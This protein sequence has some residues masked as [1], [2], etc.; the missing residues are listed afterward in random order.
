RQLGV[1]GE[2]E[3]GRLRVQHVIHPILVERHVPGD[4]DRP[5]AGGR[6]LDAHTRGRLYRGQHGVVVVGAG[7]GGRLVV[8][9]VPVAGDEVVHQVDQLVGQVVAKADHV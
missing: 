9:E 4:G 7:P 3:W 6:R 5:I 1:G 8:V 2:I